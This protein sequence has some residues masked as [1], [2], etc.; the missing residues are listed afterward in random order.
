MH[1]LFKDRKEMIESFRIRRGKTVL[2]KEINIPDGLYEKCPK[3]E[4][5]ILK[6]DI[7]EHT[8]VCTNCDYHFRL[9]AQERLHILLDIG[10]FKEVNS[11]IKSKNVLDMPG[12]SKKLDQTRK[13]N[14]TNEAVITGTGKIGGY[15]YAV[16]VMDSYFFMGSMGAVVGEKITALIELATK[17]RLPVIIFSASGGAR[18]QEGVISLM[19]MVKT[20]AALGRHSSAGLLFISAITSPTTGGVSASFAMLGDII[21]A[22]PNSLIGFAGQR[23]IQQ[24][25]GEKLP[26]GFQRS[27]FLLEKGFLDLIVHRKDMKS[28]IVKMSKLHGLNNSNK[29]VDVV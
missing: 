25:I 29:K 10:T 16:A 11:N 24:T 3:C 28:T 18:M 15:S 4:I 6:E 17:R 27:E 21:I 23:V 12:Y 20:S 9:R 7:V 5:H 1:K 13:A 8:F 26:E 19:Q 22:E 2:K 14:K